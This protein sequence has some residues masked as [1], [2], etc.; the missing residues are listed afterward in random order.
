MEEKN[1][2]GN[3]YFKDDN[4][5]KSYPATLFFK[6]N[7]FNLEIQSHID[8][9]DY[10]VIQGEFIDLGF[11]TLINCRM[12]GQTM[13]II[14]YVNYSIQYIITNV[15]FNSRELIRAS[16]MHIR[17]P[18]LK[19]WINISNL[20]GNL[21]YKKQITYLGNKSFNFFS[22]EDIEI[23]SILSLTQTTNIYE[24]IKIKEY[25]ELEI[26]SKK[27]SI[28]IFELFEFYKRIKFL[29][30]FFGFFNNE[31]DVIYFKEKNKIFENQENDIL[32]RF[33]GLF[34]N[35]T[36][37][38][39][40]Y[41]KKIYYK[42][43]EKNINLV[44]SNWLF[45]DLIKDSINLVME[46][47]LLD[48]LSVETYFLNS[49]FSIETYHRNNIN[50]KVYEENEFETIRAGLLKKITDEKEKELFLHKL[51]HAN[52]PS[53]RKR[54]KDFSQEIELISSKKNSHFINEV[55]ETRNYLV[56]RDKP[57]KNVLYMLDLYFVAIQLESL[58]KYC[59]FKQIGIN[60]EILNEKFG[61][62][63]IKIE[64]MIFLNT[65]KE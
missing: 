64:N 38:G 18:I 14:S 61:D 48:K 36:N 40:V 52:E 4:Y 26:K 17:M 35:S 65:K 30:N 28:S 53:F 32:M 59:I 47:Y 16:S 5:E 50:N 20:E 60:D 15:K 37:K 19:E 34:L 45:N 8:K 7:S 1:Y 25:A 22:N 27:G 58:T 11:V 24:G 33:Y 46:K 41:H 13:S 10:E 12:S 6:S 56:H 31:N 51:Q 9:G 2:N 54:L 63:K 21:V 55:V 49:A 39:T 44:I 62:F 42:E 29:F 3:I 23:S 43:I 57:T